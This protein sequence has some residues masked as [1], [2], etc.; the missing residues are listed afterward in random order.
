M[1]TA[2][3]ILTAPVT[4][5]LSLLIWLCAVLIDRTVF[6]FQIASAILGLLAVIVLFTTSVKNGLILLGFALA[7]SPIG[8]PMLAAK[9]L[10][11]LQRANMALKTLLHN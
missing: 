3:K 9:L 6:L 4:L 11:G 1:R 8:L 2:L 10:G 5:A 7:V